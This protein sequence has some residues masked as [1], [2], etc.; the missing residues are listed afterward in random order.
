MGLGEEVT[1][2]ITIRARIDPMFPN[3]V[4]LTARRYV[5]PDDASTAT[6]ESASVDDIVELVR[7]WLQNLR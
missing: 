7:S 5:V 6:I 3:D 2:L 4:F 1:I